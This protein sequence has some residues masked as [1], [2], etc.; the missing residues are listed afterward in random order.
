VREGNPDFTFTTPYYTFTPKKNF[1]VIVLDPTISWVP[2]G[3]FD[4]AQIKWLD[5]QLKASPKDVILIFM[6]HPIMEPFPSKDHRIANADAVDAVLHKYKNP[7]AVF[8]G[9]YH[10]SRVFQKE[11]VLYVNSP[12]M[13]SYPNA[14][15]VVNV[16]NYRSKAVV[17]LQWK[18]T[19]LKNLQKLAKMM[20]FGTTLY[21]GEEKD[22]NAVYVVKREP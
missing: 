3:R 1:K 22:R 20:V 19:G 6:H 8:T 12:A 15:R 16:K 17:E 18:E 14:F 10:A 4:E 7:I 9:H 5:K 11:N 2:N 13:V 21:A